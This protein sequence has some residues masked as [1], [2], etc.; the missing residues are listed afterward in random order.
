MKIKI[1]FLKIEKN[2]DRITPGYLTNSSI[3]TSLYYTRL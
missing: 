2:Y 1:F 3:I